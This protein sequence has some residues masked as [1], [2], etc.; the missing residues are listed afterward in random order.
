M[1]FS[2]SDYECS[3]FIAHKVNGVSLYFFLMCFVN[4]LLKLH[5]SFDKFWSETYTL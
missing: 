1:H 3:V 5:N 2:N 4:A